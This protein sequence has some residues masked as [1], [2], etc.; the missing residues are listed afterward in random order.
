MVLFPKKIESSQKGPVLGGEASL[1]KFK[2]SL[3]K[4]PPVKEVK[5]DT[6]A[7]QGKPYLKREEVRSWLRRDEAWKI[8]KIPAKDRPGLEKKLFDPK[9]FGSLVDQKEAKIVY[10]DFENFPTRVKKRYGIKDK[11][12]RVKTFNLLKKFLGK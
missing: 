1:L 6:S 2:E 12:G 5:K 8:T 9:R 10:K 7:F 11:R 3:K 4:P